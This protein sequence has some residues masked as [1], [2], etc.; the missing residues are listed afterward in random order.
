MRG[1]PAPEDPAAQEA[2]MENVAYI[3]ADAVRGM[4]PAGNRFICGSDEQRR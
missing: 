2:E 4:D 1:R 3:R